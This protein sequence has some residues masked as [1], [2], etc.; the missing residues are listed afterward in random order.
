MWYV[1]VC[2]RENDFGRPDRQ[3][4]V[5]SAIQT[6]NPNVAS[7][8]YKGIWD[9]TGKLYQEGGWRR[10]YRGFSPCLMRSVPA[11]AVLLYTVAVITDHLKV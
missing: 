8:K 10:F 7:R 9:C 4:Q 11:N 6:D 1:K 2:D 3:E 5:K